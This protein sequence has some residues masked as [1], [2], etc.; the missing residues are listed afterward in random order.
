M[1][2]WCAY[3]AIAALALTPAVATA[4]SASAVPITYYV[5]PSGSDAASGS[6]AAPFQHIARCSAV[7]VAGDTC[8]LLPGTYRETV[9]PTVS[10]TS[11]L[12]ITYRANVPGSVTIDGADP[13]TGWSTVTSGDLASLESGDAFLTGSGFATAVAAGH[14]FKASANLDA[15]GSSRQLFSDGTMVFDAQWPDPGALPSDRTFKYAGTGT[16]NTSIVS[17]ELSQPDGYWNGATI[18]AATWY[19]SQ[20]GKV[21]TSTTG[22]I[23][24]TDLEDAGLC[25]GLKPTQTTFYLSGKLSELSTATEWY[26]DSPTQT[27]Y[28]YPPTGTLPTA[29][30]VTARARN[31]AFDLSN[32]GPGV[33]YTTISGLNIHASSIQTGTSSTGILIDDLHASYV[34]HTSE[35]Q[36][37]S[38]Y[39]STGHCGATTGGTTTT[40][41]LINGTG[42]TVSNSEIAFS[43]GNG[44]ELGGTQN[45]VTGSFIHDVDYMGTYASAVQIVG[46]HETI[47]HNTM[48]RLGR[49]GVVATAAVAGVVMKGDVVAYNDISDFARIS[50]DTGAIYF[51]CKADLTGGSIDHNWVH[52][53]HPPALVSPHVGPGIYLD[54]DTGNGLVD[55]NVGWDLVQ[56]T[57]ILNSVT[58][59]SK[60]NKVYNNDGGVQIR[61]ASDAS[62]SVLQNNLGGATCL[63]TSIGGGCT[64]AVIDHNLDAS[65]DPLYVDPANADYRLQSGSPA[66]NAAVT[67]AGVTDGST[68]PT[69]S[70]GAYQYGAVR[71]VPGATL[72]IASPSG[73]AVVSGAV[74][75]QVNLFGIDIQSYNLRIDSA[76]LDYAWHPHAG[77]RTYSLDTAALSAGSHVLLATMVDRNGHK[78]TT[79]QRIVVSG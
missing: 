28:F 43:S 47:T 77:L 16:T 9:S 42:N 21:A 70:L 31:L 14:V 56:G 66:R 40:G 8:D 64:G 57:V 6:S 68:D 26:Y 2:K 48:N 44:V 78:S 30:Q 53:Y 19:L 22:Q 4:S 65:I 74:P 39:P 55:N 10:G 33:S 23:N 49:G 54:N 52:G 60:G 35:L 51:C 34:T 37:D 15:I 29:G 61:G 71:W 18:Q 50:T 38:H 3:I 1:K 27:V 13:V 46:Q 41:L 7:M 17:S 20:T 73:G 63:T 69:P 75:V 12:P 79:T 58:G 59:V 24:L 25:I 11:S 67:V 62:G 32:A 45:T 76:G 5:S 72:Q 36:N